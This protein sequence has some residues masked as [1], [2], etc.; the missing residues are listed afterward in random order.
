M[1]PIGEL[2]IIQ[3]DGVVL[4]TTLELRPPV[5]REW[6]VIDLAGFHDSSATNVYWD[7]Y[8]MGSSLFSTSPVSMASGQ[9][10]AISGVNGSTSAAA[11]N[12][13]YPLKISYT[14]YPKLVC[15]ALDAGKKLKIQGLVLERPE[16][17]EMQLIE[18]LYQHLKWD[19]PSG[20]QALQGSMRSHRGPPGRR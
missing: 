19:L 8:D 14:V 10:Y 4:S 20:I 9:R 18:D 16:N 13:Q 15:A 3:I 11:L 5:G 2:R 17:F 1:Y 7:W 12:H 6:L